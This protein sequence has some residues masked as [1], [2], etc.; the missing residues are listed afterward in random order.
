MLSSSLCSVFRRGKM[1]AEEAL[2]GGESSRAADG[3]RNFNAGGCWPVVRRSDAITKGS[4][5]QK[6]AALVDLVCLT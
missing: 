5:Y 2:L 3:R 6:A 1:A 4:P